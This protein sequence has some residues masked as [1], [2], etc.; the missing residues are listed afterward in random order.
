[1]NADQLDALLHAYSKHTLP[2]PPDRSAAGVWRE[3]EQRRHRRWWLGMF[4]V[5][6][7]RE[8]FAEP[9]LA[10]AGLA[11]ALLA[12]FLPAA[13]VRAADDG[14]LA[15]ASLHFDVFSARSP[16]MPA[17]LLAMG[18]SVEATGRRQ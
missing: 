15:R 2:P 3:I 8:L 13:A 10:I 11:V 18:V 5:L 12:G 17:T 6:S 1:M 16:G 14:H 4:P 9:R 7:W